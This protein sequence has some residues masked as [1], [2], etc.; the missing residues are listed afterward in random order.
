MYAS[1]TEQRRDAQVQILA[2][3]IY[4]AQRSRLL[5]IARRNGANGEDAE[6]AIQDAFALFIEHFDPASEAPPLAWLTLTLKRRCWALYR[7]R[8]RDSQQRSKRDGDYCPDAELP[9]DPSQHPDD[10]LD[11]A[12]EVVVIRSLLAALKPAER[13]ALS[14]IAAGYSYSE[15]G[16]I[17]GWTYTK[18]NRCLAEGR[19]RMRELA[20]A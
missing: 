9:G 13:R 12:E 14:L 16:Q 20:A 5:A 2:G 7:L 4:D 18:I 6:E 19:A 8:R 3:Q 1:T 10:L 15:V 11:L 17:T